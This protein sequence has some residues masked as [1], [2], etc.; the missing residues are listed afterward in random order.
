MIMN[1]RGASFG[2]IV[3]IIG[4]IL[5]FL[6]FAW[7]I[8]QNWHQIHSTLKIIILL[9]VTSI[10]FTVGTILHKKKYPKIGG[11]LFGLG[12]LLYTLSIFLIAQILFAPGGW[13]GTAWLWFIS[14]VGVVVAAYIFESSLS[15]IIALIEII[16]WLVAQYFAFSEMGDITSLGI[17]ALYFLALGTA[18]YGLNLWHN[19]KKHAFA[20]I[21]RWWTAFYFLLFTY[22]LSFQLFLPVIWPKEAD[23]PTSSILFLVLLTGIALATITAGIRTSLKNKKCNTKEIIGFIGIVTLLL[24]LISSTSLV[25]GVAGSCQVESCNQAP[26][27][28]NCEALPP[29]LNCQWIN[30]ICEDTSC[31]TFNEQASCQQQPSCKW[32]NDYY[33]NQKSS[34]SEYLYEKPCMNS[35]LNCAWTESHCYNKDVCVEHTTYESCSEQQICTWYSGWWYSDLFGTGGNYPLTLWVVWIAVN[36]FFIALI[37]GIIGYGTWQ[38]MPSVINLAIVFFAL[39]IFTRYVGFIADLRGYMGLSVIFITGG[40][41]LLGGGY[42]LEKWR[43]KLIIMAK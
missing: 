26:D 18:L 13:Q 37:I 25:S 2:A 16:I 17:L 34:C 11:S 4:S 15:L 5:I 20:N 39:N 19:Y 6:G 42:L 27:Q 23:S 30:N 29:Y 12:S 40:V 1:K 8:S 9:G 24:I 31:Y 41:L 35:D 43:K 7:L 22:I 36:L 21:Y 33:C 32:E 14:V 10:S 38:K 3:S 28:N